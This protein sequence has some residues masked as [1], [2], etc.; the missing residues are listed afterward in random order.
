MTLEELQ[1]LETK[2]HELMNKKLGDVSGKELMM[3]RTIKAQEELG[4]MAEQVLLT[5]RGSHKGKY[6]EREGRKKIAEEAADVLFLLVGI[7]SSCD[8]DLQALIQENFKK[9]QSRYGE[10]QPS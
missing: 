8:G 9:A 3:L 1:K 10:K 2:T 7:I 4:E 5:F 6:D